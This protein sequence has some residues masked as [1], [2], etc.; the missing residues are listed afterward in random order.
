MSKSHFKNPKGL[1]MHQIIQIS[2]NISQL[3]IKAIY[4]NAKTKLI[5]K[6][7]TCSKNQEYLKITNWKK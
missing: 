4:K 2:R 6:D 5:H 3:Q 1:N 7:S